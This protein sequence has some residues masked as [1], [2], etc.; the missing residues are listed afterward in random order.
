MRLCGTSVRCPCDDCC[1]LVTCW[2]STSEKKLRQASDVLF[3]VVNTDT[4]CC[5]CRDD[6][7]SPTETMLLLSVLR[8]ERRTTLRAHSALINAIITH[9]RQAAAE[10]T[11]G[12]REITRQELRSAVLAATSAYQQEVISSIAFELSR[13]YEALSA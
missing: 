6:A 1:G 4:N 8:D 5:G 3:D 7:L 11:D 2:L 10:G 13:D 12:G 9:L